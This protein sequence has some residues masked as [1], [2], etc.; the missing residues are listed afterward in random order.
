MQCLWFNEHI[1]IDKKAIFWKRWYNRGITKVSDI[2]TAEGAFMSQQ[3]LSLNYGLKI[4]FL[5]ALQ[6]R[7]SLPHN[8]RK[9]L[10]MQP[11]HKHL[12]KGK[13]IF[14][15]NRKENI[16]FLSLASKD[17]YWTL[18]K[19]EN[20]AVKPACMNKWEEIFNFNDKEWSE[21]FSMPFKAC[22]ET[23]L[24]T[25]QYKIIHRI[26]GCNHWLYNIRVKESPNCE[27]CNEDD[28]IIHYFIGCCG[29][30]QFWESFMTWWKSIT[31]CNTILNEFIV[32]FGTNTPTREAE[33][34][35]NCIITAK[36]Y[37]YEQK[38]KE[39]AVDFYSFL[40]Y[41]KNKVIASKDYN[42]SISKKE[43]F[44]KKWNLLL[45]NL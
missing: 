24:Q 16:D 5:E 21:I 25:F 34:F 33:I 40:P 39:K 12:P 26:F 20:K 8:W 23:R 4:T 41:L 30:E 6:I 22:K 1:S 18:F 2:L 13:L 17:V 10:Q 27:F 35:N 11:Q 31:E 15:I 42:K 37:I 29:L 7:Q 14:D 45:D 9:L 3:E 44:S 36:I 32:L 38:N 19:Q 43:E 28:T